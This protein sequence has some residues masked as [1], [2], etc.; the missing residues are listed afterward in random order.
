ERLPPGTFV[1][2]PPFHRQIATLWGHWP[3]YASQPALAMQDHR[4]STGRT[5]HRE[6]RGFLRWPQSRPA[7][8]PFLL[9]LRRNTFSMP[10]LCRP[11]RQELSCPEAR[12]KNMRQPLPRGDRRDTD[13]SCV[14]SMLE[15]R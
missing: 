14:V 10:T 4:V 1:R 8:P 2:S 11:A 9:Y 5:V 13:K 15:I 7:E 12:L 6:R 3:E